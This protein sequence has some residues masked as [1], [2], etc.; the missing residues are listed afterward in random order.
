MHP[1]TAAPAKTSGLSIA[2]LVL[3]VLVPPVG[4]ILS[5]IALIRIGKSQGRLMGKGLAVAG[6][7]VSVVI[8]FFMCILTG[9]LLPALANARAHA[10]LLKEVAS[11]NLVGTELLAH[12]AENDGQLPAVAD[13]ET[14]VIDRMGM[15]H[16]ITM[17]GAG[18]V[19]YAMNE[20]LE[21]VD[22]DELMSP[23]TTVLL[24]ECEPGGPIVGDQTLLPPRP[25]APRGYVI[26]F[27]DGTARGVHP[28]EVSSLTWEP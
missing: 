16:F 26:L 4:L 20:H 11:L 28:A 3:A 1:E 12:A 15:D 27:A 18:P 23:E 21:G 22:L 7:V 9:L 25:R 10:K 5:F 2:G 19:A 17:G 8:M 14:V 24:F 6:I 13:W